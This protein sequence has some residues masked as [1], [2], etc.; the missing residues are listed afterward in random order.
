MWSARSS[1]TTMRDGS[2]D[3]RRVDAV[4][5][6]RARATRP[7]SNRIMLYGL[8]V[9]GDQRPR[10]DHLADVEPGAELAAQPP[11]RRVGDARH[12]REHDGRRHL[13]LADRRGRVPA[14]RR[15]ARVGVAGDRVEGH[16][17][18]VPCAAAVAW[19][20]RDDRGP[21]PAGTVGARDRRSHARQARH[22]ARH[23]PSG[24]PRRHHRCRTVRPALRR[25]DRGRADRS[26]ARRHR[27]VLRRLR[28]RTRGV[29]ELRGRHRSARR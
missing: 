15:L 3:D 29:G 21:R 24:P 5:L 13:V 1:S 10:G 28:R 27:R 4:Q 11:E 18:I 23:R 8:R 12:R 19:V 25:P 7:G 17:A 26:D 2:A 6:Q 22:R 20:R 14:R 16:R 9:S